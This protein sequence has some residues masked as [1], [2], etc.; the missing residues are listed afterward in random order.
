MFVLTVDVVVFPEDSVM[1]LFDVVD[2]DEFELLVVVAV[3]E[4]ELL[5]VVV[6]D[7]FELL[8]VV[9]GN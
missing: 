7:G 1:L 6:I 2:V 5:I 9:G 4:F 3:D 8:N